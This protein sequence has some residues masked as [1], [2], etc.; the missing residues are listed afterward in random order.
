MP[1]ASETRQ[2][3]GTELL[4]DLPKKQQSTDRVHQQQ[5]TTAT[6]ALPKDAPQKLV[7][8]VTALQ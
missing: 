2:T 6:V 7:A 8:D 4:T 1:L 5:L 3:V